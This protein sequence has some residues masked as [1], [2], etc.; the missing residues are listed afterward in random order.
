MVTSFTK[1]VVVLS[2]LRNAL[3][4][5]QVPPNV[6]INGLAIILSI[7]IMY[8]VLLDSYSTIEQHTGGGTQKALDARQLIDLITTGKE[9][10]RSFLVKHSSDGE[11]AFFLHTA[12][13][14]L[15]KDPAQV[16]A[17]DYIV[18][19]PAFTVTELTTAF[20]IGFLIF[21]PFLVIDLIVANIL[22]ALG[23]MMLS[24]TTVSLPFKLMLFVFLDG[25]AK[26][27][28][29]LILTYR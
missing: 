12:R 24:P 16:G 23:M 28:H 27:V 8:P 19:V 5:Q 21:L 29:G 1:I 18:V 9:P 22:L 17:D 15:P 6:V 7:Y 11:R 26:L 10:L 25:W 14:L 2:L 20:Q 13:Q 3:G 4:L